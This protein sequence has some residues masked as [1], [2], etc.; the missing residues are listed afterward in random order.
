V[1]RANAQAACRG[2][3]IRGHF[4]PAK[5]KRDLPHAKSQGESSYLD[6]SKKRTGLEII[7]GRILKQPTELDSPMNGH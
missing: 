3:I 7:M 5:W 4:D 2:T 6:R 1:R